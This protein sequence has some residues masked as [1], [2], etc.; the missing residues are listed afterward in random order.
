MSLLSDLRDGLRALTRA[1]LFAATAVR[2]LALGLAA[3]SAIDSIADTLLALAVGIRDAARVVDVGRAN[4][5]RGFD[6]MSHPAFEYLRQH[7][8]TF[9]GLSAVEFGSRPMGLTVAGASARVF[10]TL[11]AGNFFDVLGTRPALGRFFRADEDLVPGQRPVVVLTHRCRVA[12]NA[13]AHAGRDRGRVRAHAAAGRAHRS[14]V[15]H[16]R[17]RAGQRGRVTRGLPRPDGGRP[18]A[19]L[20][21]ADPELERR[22]VG[23]G[24]AHDPPAG[25]RLRHRPH[26]H[27]RRPRAPRDRPRHRGAGRGGARVL[28][29]RRL[30]GAPGR[31]P[32]L[33]AAAPR[34]RRRAGRGRRNRS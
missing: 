25:Q 9:E 7:A 10:G 26:G 14:R 33:P 15:R 13:V 11:V 16:R 8:T 24:G 29:A 20:S 32:A 23:R 27:R 1:P 2:S 31:R 34:R 28:R 18:G 12:G 19:A 3:S 6:N 21:H 4:Q 22:R 5:G 30:A 17:H